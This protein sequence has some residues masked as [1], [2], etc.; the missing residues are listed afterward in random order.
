MLLVLA[1][2]W[3][4]TPSGGRLSIFGKGSLSARAAAPAYGQL[5]VIGTQL[6]DEKGSPVQLKGIS[7]M[8]LQWYGGV[9]NEAA[10][11]ALA[12]DWE[13]DVVRL[14][15][16]VGE[17]GYATDPGLKKLVEKGIELAIERGLYVMVDWHVLTPGNPNDPIY[18]GAEEFFREISAKY[19]RYPHVIYEIMNEPNGPL[20]W[21][22]DLKPY[23]EKIVKAIREND[24]DNIIVI[25][26]GTW[27]QDVD[28]AAADPVAGENL[29]YAVHFYA[30]THGQEL[31]SKVLR[32][33]ELGAAV[34]CTEWGTSLASGTGGPFINASEEWLSF[35]DEHK[36]S[37]INWSLCNKNETSAA[38]KGLQQE[39]MEGKGIVVLQEETPLLP[40]REGP[41]G[42][43]VWS[44]DQLTVSGAYVRAK[45]KGVD[46]PMYESPVARWTFDGGE[47]EGWHVPDDSSAKPELTIGTAESPALAFLG[48]WTEP[49]MITTWSTAPRIRV[50]DTGIP[51]GTVKKLSVDLYLEAGRQVDGLFTVVPVYQYPPSWWTQFPGVL[52]DYAKGEPV[53]NGLLKF[54]ISVPVSANPGTV[55]EHLLFVIVGNGT[56]YEGTVYIDNVTLSEVT[57]G[58]AS[59]V[60]ETERD[61][62]GE[63]AGLPW[64]FESGGRQGWSLADDSPAK[65]KPAVRAAESD[66]L[67]FSYGWSA[68]GPDDPWNAAPRLTSS[69][70][71]LPA[72]AYSKLRLEFFLE[73][74]KATTG[75][76]EVQPVI[77]S[78]QHGYWFQ[79]DLAPARFEEGER[80]ANGLLKYS[81]SF[82]LTSKGAPMNANA[83]LRNLILIT[84]GI[85][86]DYS[87]LI[88]YDNITFE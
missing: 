65:V 52:I 29:M 76:I 47:T 5:R 82:P 61:D 35:F 81:F 84:V 12:K 20:S 37:W 44:R 8:G 59:V 24:P 69:W 62:P 7:T 10:F 79:L 30:G 46:I 78:P 51:V 77:Q 26:S 72:S 23:A 60:P 87:G 56:K 58:D 22:R 13:C 54:P 21:A 68:P 42:Y 34:I 15:L 67:T 31:R 73:A 19:G 55:L 64:D 75:H 4:C 28:I 66:A 63:F 17:N 40:D 83:V 18:S 41:D 1:A 85:E 36:I 88:A 2:V 14:A 33:I 3:G 86:T 32:A 74:D 27:S 45:I 39:F 71:D 25:G 70:V 6:S 50:A 9:V 38:L 16:Y 48:S 11:T 57:N 49:R 43:P 80:T 53:G